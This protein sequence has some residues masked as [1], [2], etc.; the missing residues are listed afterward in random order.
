M[1]LPINYLGNNRVIVVEI[2]DS[3]NKNYLKMLK[4]KQ[5]FK[6]EVLD[7]RIRFVTSN[8]PGNEDFKLVL[9]GLDGLPKWEQNF[10]TDF[11]K[12]FQLIDKMPM[13]KEELKLRKKLGY[14]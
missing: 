11:Q 4:D 13:R 7:R 10:F 9:L 1:N 8:N 12:I 14:A 2:N 5:K 3:T 6:E